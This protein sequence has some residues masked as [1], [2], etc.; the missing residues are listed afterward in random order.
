MLRRP[1][2]LSAALTA[3]LT[4]S[5]LVSGAGSAQAPA[6]EPERE[7]SEPSDDA[8]DFGEDDDDAF[9][10]GGEG[11]DA[12]DFG[13][14]D[15]ASSEPAPPEESDWLDYLSITGFVRSDWHLWS[16]RFGDGENPW[17]KGRQNL[18]VAVGF[19]WEWLRVLLI[20]HAE[21]DFAYL[22]QRD[23]YDGP[24]L[25]A[26]EWQVDTREAMIQANFGAF[27]LT[28]G[29]QI[30]AW[31]E[32]DAVSPLDVVNPRD[33]REPGLSDLDDV[34]LPVLA[35]R[36]GWF[37]GD[38][39]LELMVVH[40]SRFGYRSPPR[41]PFSPFDDLL[42]TQLFDVE[43]TCAGHNDLCPIFVDQVASQLEAATLD[44]RHRQDTFAIE[45]QQVLL[46]WVY[47]G[48]GV[49][50]G[51]YAASVLDQQ[52]VIVSDFAE[53]DPTQ[54]TVLLELDHRRYHVL[55]HSGAWPH[56][57]LLF[58]WEI[59]AQ[60]LRP[61]NTITDGVTVPT[62]PFPVSEIGVSETYVI[63][64]AFGVT[65]NG[66]EDLMIGFEVSKPYL[67]DKPDNL[68]FP[69]DAPTFV[70]RGQYQLLRQRLTL[71]LVLMSM[72]W[73]MEYGWLGRAEA[74]YEILD[75]LNVYAG[76]VTFQ[77]T[78]EFGPLFGLEDHD[79]LFVKLRWD[80]QVL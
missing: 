47:K 14:D 77:P 51:L 71:S 7:A 10:F 25:D 43:T 60:L 56:E 52:G 16:E 20:G 1:R 54:D 57:S 15:D 17:A 8:F 19:K 61:F 50:L 80:F 41:G 24:T 36:L 44:Y 45:D 6:E 62:L 46:R 69:A 23:S 65:W 37:P 26:Y 9:D 66:V 42:R 30:V 21:Y 59:G 27:Q 70:L 12:F 34:R 48:A 38:H 75:G 55:G 74:S 28:L 53:L 64:T 29:R 4:S 18:D 76:Y 79:R 68:M 2:H 73:N 40:E 32:G 11:D 3:A 33:M 35:T 31:G 22:Y 5:L 58:K 13:G 39:R 49:D 78:R 72:G 67:V 63:D